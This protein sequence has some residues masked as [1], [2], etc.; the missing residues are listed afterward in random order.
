[1]MKNKENKRKRKNNLKTKRNKGITL[2]A[3]VI[4]I[5]VLLILAGVTIATLTGENGILSKAT[6]ASAQT[7]ISGEEEAISL[8]YTGALSEKLGEGTVTADDMNTQFEKNDTNAKAVTDTRVHFTD[9]DRWY[10]LDNKGNVS[11]PYESEEEIEKLLVERFCAQEDCTNPDHLHIGDYVDLKSIIKD[12]LTEPITATANATDT[13]MSRYTNYGIADQTYTLSADKNQ[14]N[15]RVL[16]VENGELKLIAGSP[17]KSNNQINNQDAPYLFMYGAESYINGP[18][19]LDYICNKLYGDGKF[20]YISTARS[21]NMNDI[22]EIT[23]IITEEDIKRVNLNPQNGG[24]QYGETY[25]TADN[26]KG[27]DW[28][29]EMWLENSETGGEISVNIDGYYYSINSK[30]TPVTAELSNATAYGLLF[31]NVE[32]PNGAQYWLASRGVRAY[33]SRARFGPGVVGTVGGMANAGTNFMFNSDGGED[34]SFAAVR[35]VVSLKSNVTIDDID[36]K[37]TPNTPDETWN[38]GG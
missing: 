9:T 31:N 17:L 20:S 22:N 37:I 10:R 21:V 30:E 32:Y 25:K 2:I 34:G 13:G 16:G 26:N 8:A 14:L 1:M 27:Y 15:W 29:P 28:T 24:Y 33:S 4:T 7:E 35:P 18:D 3:L 36:V 12:E 23:G 6:Q 38:Y 5:I 19:V 11:G